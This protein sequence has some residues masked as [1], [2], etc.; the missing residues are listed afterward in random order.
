VNKFEQKTVASLYR[1]K[2]ILVE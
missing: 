1:V 2:P